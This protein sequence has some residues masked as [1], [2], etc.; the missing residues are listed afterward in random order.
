M[1][2]EN[3]DPQPSQRRTLFAGARSAVASL[4]RRISAVAGFFASHAPVP[5]LIRALVVAALIAT[6]IALCL[7]GGALTRDP[8]KPARV[9]RVGASPLVS[10]ARQDDGF[11][12]DADFSIDRASQTWAHRLSEGGREAD[13]PGYMRF[14]PVRVS[15]AIVEH[16]LKAAKTTGSDPALLMAIADKE[17]N[18]APRAKA[19][20]S[21]AS[22]LFQFVETTWLKA[23]RAFGWRYG[24]EEAANAIGG[25]DGAPYLPP[26]KRAAILNLRNDP[27]L[28]AAL[29]AEMLKRDGD[30]IAEKLGRPLTEGETYLIH[31]LGPEDAGR[32]MAKLE[33]QPNASAARLLP[34]PAR[35]NAPIFYEQQGSRR[36]DKSVGEVHE[37]F[38]TM[39]RKRSERYQDI[40]ARLPKGVAA[41]AQ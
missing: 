19:S 41:Y 20:T 13:P 16:V 26:A 7:R 37:A 29:A 1:V 10:I 24:H 17:S 34:R 3:I 21:S 11:P 9:S 30:K 18:F 12:L 2:Y 40:E 35:A 28:S 33:E 23:V 6:L 32:F 4:G 27:Y 22:G 15:Q 8:V 38:E 14:G 31:F 25:D 5:S 39:M 36:K